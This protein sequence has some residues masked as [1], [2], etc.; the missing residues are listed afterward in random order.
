MLEITWNIKILKRG[1]DYWV[2]ANGHGLG[3]TT[4]PDRA[5][6]Y[7]NADLVCVVER[8]CA[9]LSIRMERHVTYTPPPITDLRQRP[10][11]KLHTIRIHDP[12]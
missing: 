1:I 5:L 8:A 12:P 6:R 11:K 2:E 4:T 7:I 9:D 10:T 3:Y